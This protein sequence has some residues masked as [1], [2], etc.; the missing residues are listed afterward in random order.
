[1]LGFITHDG[2]GATDRV[3]EQT[4]R[5]LEARGV[6]LAGA[7]QENLGGDDTTPCDMILRVL[8]T[9]QRFTISQSLGSCAV[10]CRL[11]P[12]GFERTVG[13]VETT[14]RED[15]ALLIINKFGK[16]EIEGRGFRR[17]IGEALMQGIPVLT[18]TGRNHRDA[19]LEFAGDMAEQI[20]PDPQAISDWLARQSDAMEA[21]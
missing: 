20:D 3:L 6:V 9:D 18:S 5:Q 15:T 4:A 8:G 10:G 1:M 11:D 17:V 2:R 14:L 13:L 7:V 21:T 16:Q 12:D 19:F